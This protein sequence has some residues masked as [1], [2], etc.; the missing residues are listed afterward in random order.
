MTLRL[1]G[2]RFSIYPGSPDRW[3]ERA[4]RFDA[5]D[6]DPFTR[7]PPEPF[8]RLS[9]F[10][11]VPAPIDGGSAVHETAAIVVCLVRGPF[12]GCPEPAQSISAATGGVAISVSAGQRS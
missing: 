4:L 12:P 10:G 5:V 8:G 11:L 6:A 3:T 1:H 9:P 7:P 2:Y